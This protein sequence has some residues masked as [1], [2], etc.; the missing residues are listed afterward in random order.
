MLR[1]NRVTSVLHCECVAG[2]SIMWIYLQ[3]LQ[4]V[5]PATDSTES[6][7]SRETTGYLQSEVD[8]CAER[9]VDLV[10]DDP[11]MSSPEILRQLKQGGPC[12]S[13]RSVAHLF[14]CPSMFRKTCRRLE[15][16][17]WALVARRLDLLPFPMD[18]QRRVRG[19]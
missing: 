19:G 13:E 8:G 10:V 15:V 17:R 16:F 12:S 3:N 1:Y 11:H 2:S 4:P 7:E 5:G 18:L 14:G 6:A 9:I